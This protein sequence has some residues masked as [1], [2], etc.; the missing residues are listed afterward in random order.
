[1]T[2]KLNYDIIEHEI[3]SYNCG[4]KIKFVNELENKIII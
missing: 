2:M 3:S 4:D 1:V